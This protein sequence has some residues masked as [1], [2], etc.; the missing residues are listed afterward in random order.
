M[1]LS[2]R[3]KIGVPRQHQLFFAVRCSGP[4]AFAAEEFVVN[5][6]RKKDVAAWV[7]ARCVR[8][9]FERRVFQCS[10]DVVT[11]P[12]LGRVFGTRQSEI[13]KLCHTCAAHQY[14]CELQ[15]AM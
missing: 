1:H 2:E 9:T 12:C 8:A 5:G 4:W 10:L 13:H 3:P 11:R 15:V 14:V 6:A 7:I